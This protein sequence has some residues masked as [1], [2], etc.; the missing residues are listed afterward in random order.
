MSTPPAPVSPPNAWNREL[1]P[2]GIGILLVACGLGLGYLG[3]VMP[4]RDA[5]AHAS[6]VSLSFKA[7]FLVPFLLGTGLLYTC[8]PAWMLRFAGHPQR[9]EK[10]AWFLYVPLLLLGVA[11]HLYV[12]QTLEGYGYILP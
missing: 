2:R 4:I 1:S 6:S 11:L 5:A 8:A 12:K 7:T 3:V 10:R 9:P